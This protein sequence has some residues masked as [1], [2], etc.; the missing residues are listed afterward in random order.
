M[1]QCVVG[2]SLPAADA[3]VMCLERRRRQR[4]VE[5]DVTLSE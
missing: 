4:L 3:D 1:V 5:R 2:G